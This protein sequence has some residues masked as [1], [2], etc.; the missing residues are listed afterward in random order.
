MTA[1]DETKAGRRRPPDE[2]AARLRAA[3]RRGRKRLA[4]IF[5]LCGAVTFLA[6]S[7]AGATG[8]T[9]PNAT[10]GVSDPHKAGI[11]AL[12]LASNVSGSFVIPGKAVALP[13]PRTG[14]GAVVIGGAGLVAASKDQ[15]S[16]PI[17]SV[18]KIMT[19]YLILWDHPL[20]GNDVGPTFTMTAA[21]HTA[22]IEASEADESNI[23]VKAGERLDER[24]LLQALMIPSAD[25]IADYLAAWDAGSI[26]AFVAKMNA[27]ATS[28][29]LTGTHFA[30]ASGV[31]PGSRGTAVDMARLA[32]I[33]MMNPVL[34]SITDEQFIKLPVSGEIWNNYDP[35]VGVDGIIGVKSGFTDA[36]QT[37]L[38]T[39]AF[40]KVG[41]RRVLVVCDV[42]NQPNTLFGDA[43]E[44]EALLDAVTGALRLTKVMS[45]QTS[46]AL[47]T[48]AWNHDT[49]AVQLAAPVAVVGWPGLVLTSRLV[50]VAASASAS[51][52]GWAAGCTIGRLD[53]VYPYGSA[54]TAPLVL[55]SAIRPPPAGWVPPGTPG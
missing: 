34:R 32:A 16:V 14:E 38:V 54:L 52:H 7:L 50:Q 47:A 6:V 48:T 53:F 12:S 41:G 19:A 31:N 15:K 36:A 26:K 46:V 22:W 10:P 18:T 28:L 44:D 11:E 27:M 25:N 13:F 24:Q 23:E 55:E 8:P 33:A 37:N 45:S 40:R 30:D 29:H 51:A 1:G 4:V 3:R 42:I 35:A 43:Q 21:D 49:S 5:A 9:R 17:A 2:R 39:A 20:V